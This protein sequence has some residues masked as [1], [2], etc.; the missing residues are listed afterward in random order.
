[1]GRGAEGYVPAA[2]SGA[3]RARRWQATRRGPAGVAAVCAV[4]AGWWAPGA[5]GQAEGAAPAAVTAA[6]ALA[7]DEPYEGRPVSEIVFEGLERASERYARNQLRTFEGRPLSW[8]VVRADVRRL[9]RLGEF[10]RVGAEVTPL[11]DGTVRVTYRLSEAPIIQDIVVV[12]NKSVN[13]EDIARVVNQRVSLIAG[14]PIDEYRIGQAQRA[15][16]DLYRDRGFY[17]VEVTVDRSELESQ[18]VVLFRV[19][20]G[21]RT[22]VTAVRFEG[23]ESIEA[24]RL[25][26]EL[27]TKRRVLFF[28]APLDDLTLDR[29][30]ARLVEV[31]RNEGYLDVRAARDI[32]LSPDGREAI[33]TFLIEEGPLYTLRRVLVEGPEGRGG[34]GLEVFG[35]DQIRGLFPLKPGDVYEEDEVADAVEAVRES[36]RK[37]GYVDARVRRS[38]LR[39]I[40]TPEV[41]VVLGVEEGDRFRAGLVLVQ[42][43]ELTQAKVV[44]RRVD[45]QPG[46]WLDGS[47]ADE[48]E[49]RLRA[50]GLFELNPAAGKPPTVTILPE[51][52]ANPGY[53]D[54]LVEVQ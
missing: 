3:D 11:A 33:V 22:Q 12:G 37:I 26:A 34:A 44:R 17:R 32:R 1:M 54:V 36:Y 53:R 52:E 40:E 47:A 19:R 16:E 21:D 23:N 7:Q 41:D 35:A 4:A 14:V 15:I 38:E 5:L 43:N 45:I 13:D 20:E 9:E 31:Y 46:E 10:E 51:A 39:A 24:K 6:A 2:V 27:E 8:E 29:D 25:K 50:S 18:G 49:R 42:G 28:N 30:V 48:T